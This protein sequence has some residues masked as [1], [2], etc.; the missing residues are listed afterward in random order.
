MRTI[1]LGILAVNIVFATAHSTAVAGEKKLNAL[2]SP[3]LSFNY[4]SDLQPLCLVSNV[5][6]TT[7]IPV[8]VEIVDG[9]GEIAVTTTLELEPHQ[10][11]AA[12]GVLE[13]FYSYCRIMPQDPADLPLLRGSHCMV[14]SNT[15]ITCVE[16]R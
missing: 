10:T 3:A 4:T 6:E 12:G 1:I 16:A 13:N 15:V 2:V 7:T 9:S 5:S 14:S 11:D 8:T